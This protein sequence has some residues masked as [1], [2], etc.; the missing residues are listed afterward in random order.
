MASSAVANNFG[1]S[2]ILLEGPAAVSAAKERE[3]K[4]ALQASNIQHAKDL[5]V[6]V[7]FLFITTFIDFCRPKRMP[8]KKLKTKN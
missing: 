3:A 5:R 8:E 4:N 7:F 2:T 1:P 6:N